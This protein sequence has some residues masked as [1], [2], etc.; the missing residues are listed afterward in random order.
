MSFEDKYFNVFDKTKLTL[1]EVDTLNGWFD[2]MKKKYKI[3][4]E[5]HSSKK[6]E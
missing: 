1:L 5:I 3:V 6:D 4:A 2:Y